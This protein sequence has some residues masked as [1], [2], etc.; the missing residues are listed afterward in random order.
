MSDWDWT[1]AD[2]EPVVR[3]YAAGQSF[4]AQVIGDDEFVINVGHHALHMRIADSWALQQEITR[5]RFAAV[6]P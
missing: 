2:P 6:T 4:T 3:V 5:A 1:D